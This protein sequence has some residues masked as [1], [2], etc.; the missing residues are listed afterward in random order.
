MA[1]RN[2]DKNLKIYVDRIF[3]ALDT[4]S[5]ITV[6][7]VTAVYTNAGT[8]ITPTNLLSSSGNALNV[9]ATQDE[10]G[11]TQGAVV[12]EARVSADVTLE[13]IF[14]GSLIIDEDHMVGVD[15]VANPGAGAASMLCWVA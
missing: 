10:T 5:A 13:I 4:L 14:G 8:A 1:V 3:V 15:C 12:Y 6:H 7:R 11:N 2:N 9:D